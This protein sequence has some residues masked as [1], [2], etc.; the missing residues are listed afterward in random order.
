MQRIRRVLVPRMSAVTPLVEWGDRRLSP[1][2]WQSVFVEPNTGCWLREGAVSR[3][4]LYRRLAYRTLIGPLAEGDHLKPTCGLNC[5]NPTHAK[6]RTPRTPEQDIAARKRRKERLPDWK[7]QRQWLRWRYGLSLADFDRMVT[8][9]DGRC[10]ICSVEFGDAFK[11]KPRV[12][13]CHSAGH[14]RALLC[15]GCNFGLGCFKDSPSALRAAADYIESHAVAGE[16]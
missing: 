10:A 9:Q 13:H 6:A 7:K 4:C 2:F 14:V 8:K 1:L 11:D 15:S 16:S 12:D 3:V 5:V